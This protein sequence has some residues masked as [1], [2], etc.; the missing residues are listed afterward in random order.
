VT[1]VSNP[2]LGFPL[3]IEQVIKSRPIGSCSRRAPLPRPPSRSGFAPTPTRSYEAV[4]GH[5]E[6]ERVRADA[7]EE[8]LAAE[9][10]LEAGGQDALEDARQH[11]EPGQGVQGERGGGREDPAPVPERGRATD[12]RAH[13]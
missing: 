8:H 3:G 5:G 10:R 1:G 7:L 2:A 13:R 11:E 12:E 9:R 6:R 4:D